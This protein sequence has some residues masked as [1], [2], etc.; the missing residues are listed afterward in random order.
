ATA[1]SPWT[2]AHKPA[3]QH[4]RTPDAFLVLALF[5]RENALAHPDLA[6]DDPIDRA[7]RGDLLRPLRP[8]ARPMAERVALALPFRHLGQSVDAHAKLE[9]VQH[10]HRSY[11]RSA[12]AWRA[13]ETL[14][15]AGRPRWSEIRRP[16]A[17]KASRSTP[18]SMP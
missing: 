4:D 8:T 15:I 3:A 12:A 18:V 6:L 7:A 10:R 2:H 13:R 16:A 9:H 17:I 5:E 1:M 14:D 11:L